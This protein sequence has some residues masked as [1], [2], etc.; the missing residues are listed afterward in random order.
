MIMVIGS[1]EAKAEHRD[2]ILAL[3]VNHVQRSR[4]EAGCLD[5]RV[6]IDAENEHRFVFVEYWDSMAA[7]KVHFD[8]EA[9][10][11]FVQSL[12]PMVSSKPDMQIFK[13]ETISV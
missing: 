3:C 5:H 1:V 4:K 7:L 8:L 6:S 9:S 13:T 12:M 10:K 2:E 11:G